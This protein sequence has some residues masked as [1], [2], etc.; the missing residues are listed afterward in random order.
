MNV[1]LRVSFPKWDSIE[2]IGSIGGGVTPPHPRILVF[3]EL[4][5]FSAQNLV[6][7]GV[8]AKI[9]QTKELAGLF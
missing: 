6:A 1:G 9:A 8:M 4:R 3:M 5:T 2:S 7:V